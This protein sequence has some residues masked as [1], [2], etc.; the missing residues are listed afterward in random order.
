MICVQPLP[1]GKRNLQQKNLQGT[2]CA[3]KERGRDSTQP[4]SDEPMRGTESPGVI[5]PRGTGG[6]R[7]G[8]YGRDAVNSG[9][10][11]M[12]H[13]LLEKKCEKKF[14][15]MLTPTADE[16]FCVRF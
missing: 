16:V 10:S 13:G 1:A 15:K 14:K 8:G 12:I 3:V 5:C 9:L 7:E 4:A 6:R 11:S 2:K